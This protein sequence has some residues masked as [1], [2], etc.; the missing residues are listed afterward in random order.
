M[1]GHTE[2]ELVNCGVLIPLLMG[3][4]YVATTIDITIFALGFILCTFYVT[5]DLDINSKPYGRWKWLRILWWP[6]KTMFK[7]RGKSH[8]FIWGPVSLIGY[9]VIIIIP[10]LVCVNCPIN[11]LFPPISGMV[12]AIELHIITDRLG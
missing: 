2:H 6:Y 9:L 12:L 4:T 5:P 1:P 7:H 11:Y 8:H 3:L 10:I